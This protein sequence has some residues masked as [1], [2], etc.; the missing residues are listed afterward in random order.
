[1]SQ[2]NVEIVREAMDAFNRRDFDAFVPRFQPDVEW[3]DSEGFPGV[4]G[5]YHGRAGVREWW[6]TWLEAWESFHFEIEEITE[7]S[8]DRV[9]FGGLGTGRGKGSGVETQART[10]YVLW[11]EDGKLAGRKLFWTRDDAI[12][13]AGLRE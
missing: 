11:F 2:E 1:M 3:D 10:W 6:E 5:V 13:A 7:G 12:E 8:G 9:L 4:G